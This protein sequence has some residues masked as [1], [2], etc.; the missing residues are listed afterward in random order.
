MLGSFS[1]RE[2]H[3]TVHASE[4]NQRRWAAIPP[5]G[6][7][8]HLPVELQ[9]PA[10]RRE[11]Y[12]GAGDVM[13]RLSWHKPAATLRTEFFKPEKGRFL[14]PDEDR[15]LTH[16][17]AALLQGFPDDYRWCGSKASIARQIGNAVPVG[18]AR[19][20]AEHIAMRCQRGASWPL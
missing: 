9:M 7:R 2:L 11:E 20:V 16:R 15:P 18:L 12:K 10:W 8:R 1:T 5:G 14:H 19:A 6:A 13:G 4:M 17:E 3:L